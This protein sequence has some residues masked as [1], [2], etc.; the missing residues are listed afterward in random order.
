MTT[1]RKFAEISCADVVM[2]FK[3]ADVGLGVEFRL[4]QITFTI[5]EGMRAFSACP[6]AK[7][8]WYLVRRI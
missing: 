7:Y 2:W 5:A 3:N 6:S 4:Y 8:D 1:E